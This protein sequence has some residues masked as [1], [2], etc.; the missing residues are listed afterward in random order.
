[1]VLGNPVPVV[2]K[3]AVKK[4]KAKKVET[5]KP[6]KGKTSVFIRPSQNLTLVQIS[7][8]YYLLLIDLY[9][10]VSQEVMLHQNLS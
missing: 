2:P 8:F 9:H 1:M 4:T 6:K 7:Y 5:K 3:A 10:V